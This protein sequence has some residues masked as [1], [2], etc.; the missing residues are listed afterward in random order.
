MD[1]KENNLTAK[2]GYA[3]IHTYYRASLLNRH[4]DTTRLITLH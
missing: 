1:S 3:E 4:V 2:F